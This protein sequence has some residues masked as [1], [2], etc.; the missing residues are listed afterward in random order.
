MA[1]HS[2]IL[3]WRIPWSHGQRSLS[4]YSLC[5]RKESNMA[6]QLTQRHTNKQMID[7]CGKYWI[8]LIGRYRVGQEVCWD[9]FKRHW[10][11]L[12]T[13]AVKKFK[14]TSWLIQQE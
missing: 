14:Q 8:I 3:A 12:K 4:G 2:S 11:N 10:K 9:F 6:V 1:I 7:S 13:S 5:G